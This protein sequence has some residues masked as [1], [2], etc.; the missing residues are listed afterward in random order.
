[1]PR[2]VFRKSEDDFLRKYYRSKSDAELG[3][4]LNASK[5]TIKYRLKELELVRTYDEEYRLRGRKQKTR[6]KLKIGDV[7]FKDGTF[8]IKDCKA[9]SRPYHEY[10][11]NKE[12]G[13]ILP[14]HKVILVD[15]K[16]DELSSY[17]A[18]NL[19]LKRITLLEKYAMSD[20]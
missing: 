9:G 11:Y 18:E 17:T 8:R 7:F 12:I 2:K 3:D 14:N 6:Y 10:V 5:R 19:T 16:Y 20:Y 1:M 4:L 15:D 13:I